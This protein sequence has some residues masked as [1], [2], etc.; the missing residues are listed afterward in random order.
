MVQDGCNRS[1]WSERL[2]SRERVTKDRCFGGED[3]KFFG[4]SVRS[5]MT[6]F[7]FGRLFNLHYLK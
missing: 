1:K 4:L 3:R 2:K 5:E 7:S 6:Q